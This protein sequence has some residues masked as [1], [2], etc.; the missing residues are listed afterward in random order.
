MIRR[1]R[2]LLSLSVRRRLS[3][4]SRIGQGLPQHAISNLFAYAP[5]WPT[6]TSPSH[7]QHLVNNTT[8]HLFSGTTLLNISR[9]LACFTLYV[10]GVELSGTV[11]CSWA[12]VSVTILHIS[13]C[14]DNNYPSYN[15]SDT[16]LVI[17]SPTINQA[18]KLCR[19]PS[20]H[21]P[22]GVLNLNSC[23]P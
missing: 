22:Y 7:Q 4:L 16:V 10:G 1:L 13:S 3:S 2:I 14:H 15:H 11:P 21:K 5:A 9:L 19:K 12:R 8:T 17:K 6:A 18:S 23:S 20:H